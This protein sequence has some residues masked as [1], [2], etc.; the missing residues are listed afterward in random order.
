M[1]GGRRSNLREIVRRKN[2]MTPAHPSRR[3]NI[4]WAS[5]RG[6]VIRQ[7]PKFLDP[8]GFARR[9]GPPVFLGLS[10]ATRI[11]AQEYTSPYRRRI[12]L[13]TAITTSRISDCR[14]EGDIGFF[15]DFLRP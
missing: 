5:R 4:A 3:R 8:A 12:D 9:R 15:H 11:A 6:R 2:G 14:T 7:M 1:A 13:G 10:G